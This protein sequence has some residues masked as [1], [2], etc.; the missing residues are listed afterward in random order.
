LVRL[1]L[2]ART[3]ASVYLDKQGLPAGYR[4]AKIGVQREKI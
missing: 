2:H 1:M 3:N 4:T